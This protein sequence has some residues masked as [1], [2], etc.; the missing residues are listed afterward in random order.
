MDAITTM[1]DILFVGD[2]ILNMRTTYID[3][4][5]DEVTDG[6]NFDPLFLGFLLG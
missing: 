5:H 6:E 2:V 4:N 3:G 1:V